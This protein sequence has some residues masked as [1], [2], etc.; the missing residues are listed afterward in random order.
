M[1]LRRPSP[2]MAVALLALFVALGGTSYATAEMIVPND[3]VGT[4][5]IKNDS[6][7]RA[8]LAHHSITSVLIKPGA[9]LASDFAAGQLP[10][11]PQGPVGPQGA[12]GDKGDKGDAGAISN[13]KVRSASTT[14]PAGGVGIVTASC[15]SD[16]YA[17]GAGSSW[18]LASGESGAGLSTVS[19]APSYDSNGVTAYVGRGENQTASTHT[20]AVNVLCFSR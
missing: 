2:S 15:R 9:L 3:S 11:G 12:K 6:V 13:I 17:S 20:F 19:L 16:E 10:A 5:Q 8:K 1:M 14:V 4:A 18:S 7:T